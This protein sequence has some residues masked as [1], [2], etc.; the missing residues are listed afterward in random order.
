MSIFGQIFGSTARPALPDG[1]TV[2]DV[3]TPA[4]FAGGHVAGSVNIPLDTV[5]RELPRFQAIT[6]PIVLVCASGNRSGQATAWLRAQGLTNV[7]N[8]G[9]WL[10][11]R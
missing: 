11:F 7:E 1:A 2:I 10:N 5:Q 6:G 8:G 9:S 3:R 4:E